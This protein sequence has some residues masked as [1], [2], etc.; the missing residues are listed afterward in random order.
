MS[1]HDSAENGEGITSGSWTWRPGGG[2]SPTCRRGA[3]HY[4]N[5]SPGLMAR[6]VQPP[7]RSE[8]VIR[9]PPR[10]WI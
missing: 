1:A 10:R 6:G 5:Y 9:A 3:R 8:V 4:I 7:Q 2:V